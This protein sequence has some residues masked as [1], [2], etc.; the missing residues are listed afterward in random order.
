MSTREKLENNMLEQERT[1]RTEL[2]RNDQF[3]RK[4]GTTEKCPL[5]RS[6]RTTCWSKSEHFA[7]SYRGTTSSTAKWVRPRNVHSREAGEQHV[8]ARANT[9]H[10]VTE[11]RPV[12]P[13]KISGAR[14]EASGYTAQAEF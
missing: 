10:G 6:W 5:E 11:E 12:P 7:R 1:L 2:Q 13:Q 9:S 8:G 14:R 4:M 3:H